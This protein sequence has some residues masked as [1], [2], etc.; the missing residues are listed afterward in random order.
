MKKVLL[1]GLVLILAVGMLAGC[2]KDD[3]KADSGDLTIGFVSSNLNDTGQTYV[4]DAA[5]AYADEKGIEL[6]VQDAQDDVAKQQDQV[7]NLITQ[8]VNALIVVPVDT[9]AMKPITQAAKNA[10]IPLVYVNRNP[11]GEKDP[12][13][14]TY[15]VGSKEIEAGKMQAEY[16]VKTM[17]EK[18]N[19]AIL[20][21][22]L[23]NEGAVKRTEGNTEI[24]KEYKDI[25]IVAKE[26]GDWQKDKGLSLTENWLTAYGK[27]LKAILANNDEMALG[28]VKALEAAGRTD[29]IVMGVDALPDAVQA[30]KDGK[31]T[32]TVLQDLAGQGTKGME[33]AEA[34]ANKKDPEKLTWIDFTLVTKDNV[35]E[36]LK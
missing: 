29:V 5:Q 20:Q 30:V 31:L 4:A 34:A 1:L 21:G 15:F 35:D 10:D 22:L 28:A 17:G 32:A 7:N 12:E 11:F 3:K 18:G 8:G 36:Y 13:D 19:V 9:A 14:N 24:L 6:K 33:I 16:L 2:G 27:D 26:A 25:K 23:T